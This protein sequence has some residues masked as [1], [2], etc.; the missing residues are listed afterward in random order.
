M[1]M[2]ELERLYQKA[3]T[4]DE[5]D[6]RAA[7]IEALLE[8]PLREAIPYH[9]ELPSQAAGRVSARRS[10]SCHNDVSPRQVSRVTS[11]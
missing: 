11:G 7:L 2:P 1:T 9:Y 5:I 4:A 8:S 3:K 10:M 6:D